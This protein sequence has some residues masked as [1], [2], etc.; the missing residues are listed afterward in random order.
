MTHIPLVEA[1][2]T[3]S[4][5]DH[6][7]GCLPLLHKLMERRLPEISRINAVMWKRHGLYGGTRYDAR[8]Y[9]RIYE[10]ASDADDT[11]LM[12]I[13]VAFIMHY[14][15]HDCYTVIGTAMEAMWMD[16]IS[17]DGEFRNATLPF[18]DMALSPL[19]WITSSHLS[20]QLRT[21]SLDQNLVFR[22]SYLVAPPPLP[23]F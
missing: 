17:R 5:R 2:Y 15:T 20:D 12:Q 4:L 11:L 23:P 8:R 18:E 13:Y 16:L 19:Y 9:R 7:E 14:I 3:F 21:I 22:M 1:R 10:P 6:F